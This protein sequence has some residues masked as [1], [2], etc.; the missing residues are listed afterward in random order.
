MAA[1]DLMSYNLANWFWNEDIWLPP[2]VT[3]NDLESS[4]GHGDQEFESVAKFTDLWYPIPAAFVV[5]AVRLFF[6]RYVMF[7]KQIL[8]RYCHVKGVCLSAACTHSMVGWG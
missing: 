2:N 5:I 3:W 1:P 8:Y 6:E 7:T 4:M